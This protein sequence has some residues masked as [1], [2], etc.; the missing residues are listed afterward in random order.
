MEL[1][2][3]IQIGKKK[4]NFHLELHFYKLKKMKI[5]LYDYITLKQYFS[6]QNYFRIKITFFE[7]TLNTFIC[8]FY[9]KITL[10]LCLKYLG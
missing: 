7:K 3:L 6:S 8:I 5:Y 4:F 10:K 2:F 1:K 9:G